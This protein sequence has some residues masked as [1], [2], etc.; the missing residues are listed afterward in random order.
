MKP[1]LKNKTIMK[2]IITTA[3]ALFLTISL[4]TLAIKSI[5]L[6]QNCTG[7]LKRAAD[8]NTVEAAKEELQ[9]AIDYLEEN[10]ITS[11]YT[12]IIYKTPDEDI[13]FW[14]N[15]LKSSYEEL[16]K[17]TDSTSALE[18]TNLLMKLRETLL[19]NGSEGDKLTIPSGLV[20]YP[21]NLMWMF[22]NLGNLLIVLVGGGYVFM[23]I[24]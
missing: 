22:I 2:T 1:T 5:N 16:S 3:L 13:A 8:A 17:V 9:K 6:D 24:D 12:S 15:N 10:S 7:Y 4:T 21:N 19:D 18:R 20:K 14:Y 11:G 23:K